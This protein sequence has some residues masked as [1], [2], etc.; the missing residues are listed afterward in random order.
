VI[1]TFTKRII[2]FEY[3]QL[4]KAELVLQ[5]VLHMLMVLVAHW[6]KFPT[7]E[8]SGE[9]QHLIYKFINCD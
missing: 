5:H 2:N 9:T 8:T 3:N 1:L 7:Y 4:L 6:V